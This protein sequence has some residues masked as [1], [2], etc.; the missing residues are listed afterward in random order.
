MIIE[1]QDD[2]DLARIADSGQCFRWTRTGPDSF[3]VLH[4]ADCLHIASLGGG[5]FRLDC[6]EAAFETVWRDYFDLAENYAAIRAA[7]DPADAFL[8]AAAAREKGIRILRQDPWEALASFILSQNK[9]I[10]AI[11]RA[12]EALAAA[13]GDQRTDA[14]GAPYFAFPA[15]EAVAALSEEA[16]RRCGLGYRCAYL[17]AA[18]EAVCSGALD[19]SALQS[20]DEA[21]TMAALTGLFGVGVKVAACVSLFGLH[22]LDAFPQD[23]WIKR[24]LAEQ[25]PAGYPFAA[26]APYNGV[27]QQY[28]FAYYRALSRAGKED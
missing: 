21:R 20:A 7:I 14:A 10:P 3:R 18:A 24:I 23:V 9:N 8:R 13:C 12:V 2:F 27:Y 25:Y 16:L 5:R 1:I 19:L 11:R 22:H 28:M 26:Y 6:S 17:H 4:G 15:P